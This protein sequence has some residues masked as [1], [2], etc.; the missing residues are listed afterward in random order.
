MITHLNGKLLVSARTEGTH[1]IANSTKGSWDV[2]WGGWGQL[3]FGVLHENCEFGLGCLEHCC[4]Y[5]ILEITI[6]AT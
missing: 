3:Y 4:K 6:I 5:K 2:P 1:D